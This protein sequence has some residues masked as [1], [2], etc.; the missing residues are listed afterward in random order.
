MSLSREYKYIIQL[1]KIKIKT[2]IFVKKELIFML[3]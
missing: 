3:T 1:T 2:Y